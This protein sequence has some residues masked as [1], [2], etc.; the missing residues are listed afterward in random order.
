M[1]DYSVLEISDG[2]GAT[3]PTEPTE[4]VY[5]K[6]IVIDLRN[7]AD[8]YECKVVVTRD[9]VIVFEETVAKG[10]KSITIPA[11]TGS[12]AQKY[13]VIINDHDGWD[14]WVDFSADG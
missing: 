5:T 3:E 4:P 1:T 10:T 8:A 2:S 12:G 11:Q 13:V 6:D 14:E 9:G 7:S